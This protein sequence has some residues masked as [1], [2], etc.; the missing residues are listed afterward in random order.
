MV[1]ILRFRASFLK[2][3]FVLYFT[4]ILL[5]VDILDSIFDFYLPIQQ[6]IA[7]E[8]SRSNLPIS[9]NYRS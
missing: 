9:Y 4:K 7:H 8:S 3:K 6:K 2:K 5:T 1:Q